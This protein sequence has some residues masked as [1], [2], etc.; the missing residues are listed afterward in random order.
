MME[1][2]I[3]G[4][5]MLREMNLDQ[6]EL[7]LIIIVFMKANFLMGNSMDLEDISGKAEIIMKECI[8]ME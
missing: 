2:Y 8:R 1:E 4:K 3:M 7:F 5:L 6:V